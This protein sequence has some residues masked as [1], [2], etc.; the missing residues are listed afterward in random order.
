MKVSG[1]L[2]PLAL[3]A[4]LCSC[5]DH[6]SQSSG[7]SQQAARTRDWYE[8]GESLGGPKGQAYSQDKDG[9]WKANFNKRSSFEQVDRDS[10]YFKGEN[11]ATKK[12]YKTGEFNKKSWWGNKEFGTKSYSGDTDGSRFAKA[13]ALG[14]QRAREISK[15]AKESGNHSYATSD[16]ATND[17]REAAGKMLDKPSDAETDVRRKVFTQPSVMDWREQRGMTLKDTKAILGR[18]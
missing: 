7:R 11:A 9:S 1:L 12:A 5:A 3:S 18:E 2:L 6:S 10:P 8:W 15:I 16:Y 4:A 14:D 17:A 13:S